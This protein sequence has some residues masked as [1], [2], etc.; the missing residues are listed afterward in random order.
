MET[1]IK[2]KAEDG[3]DFY[4]KSEAE[5]HDFFLKVRGVLRYASGPKYSEG[6]D[7]PMPVYEPTIQTLCHH[8]EKVRHLF[9]D[10]PPPEPEIVTRTETKVERRW[11]HWSMWVFLLF[12]GG[13]IGYF[14]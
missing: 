7:G 5:A 1:V 2:Y 12:V 11:P 8:R 13:A 10:V 4:R 3:K 9:L 14:L 6:Y